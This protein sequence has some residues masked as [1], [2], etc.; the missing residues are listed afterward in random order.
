MGSFLQLDSQ[1]VDYGKNVKKKS[2]G[3]LSD[4]FFKFGLYNFKQKKMH[5]KYFF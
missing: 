5:Y 4:N 1:L 2:R 3:I